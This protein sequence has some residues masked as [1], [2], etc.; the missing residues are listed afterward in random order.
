MLLQDTRKGV[1]FPDSVLLRDAIDAVADTIVERGGLTKRSSRLIV[2]GKMQLLC[3]VTS[4]HGAVSDTPQHGAVSNQSE[5]ALVV[6]DG[7]G[8]AAATAAVPVACSNVNMEHSGRSTGV[9][10]TE[11]TYALWVNELR[12]RACSLRLPVGVPS[13]HIRACCHPYSAPRKSMLVLVMLSC[14]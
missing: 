3:I 4:N 8:G 6:S 14:A 1:R 5:Y 13:L 7:R 12:V 9:D 10:K 2:N 11:P